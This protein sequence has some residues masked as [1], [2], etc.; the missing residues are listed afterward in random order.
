MTPLLISAAKVGSDVPRLLINREIVG[1]RMGASSFDFDPETNKRD[2]LFL[3]DC[4]DG[5]RLLAAEMGLHGEL[6]ELVSQVKKR[7]G[8]GKRGSGGW[9]KSLCSKV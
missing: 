4:D 2:A 7:P 8:E 6:A 9:L 3:G 1:R 5:A